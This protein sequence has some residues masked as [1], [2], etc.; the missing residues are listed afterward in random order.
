MTVVFRGVVVFIGFPLSAGVQTL[1]V[2]VVVERLQSEA[3][4]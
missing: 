3:I 1:F 2:S 4:D